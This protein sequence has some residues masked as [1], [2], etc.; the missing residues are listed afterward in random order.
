MSQKVLSQ[1][2]ADGNATVTLNRPE[3]HN[4]FDAETVNL[5]TSTLTQLEA[6]D[7]VRAVVLTGAGKSFSA[8]AE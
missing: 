8:G 5:L 1:I 3:V 4:A 7:R 2:D 6:D